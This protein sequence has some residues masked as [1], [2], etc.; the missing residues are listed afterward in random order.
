MHDL[1]VLVVDDSKV[2]RVTMMK[3]LEAMGVKVD[4]V[5]S[6][7]Q[8]LEYLAQGTPDMIFMDHMMP[9]MDGF[10]VTRRIKANPAT[11]NIPVVIISGNEEA[12]FV[13]EARAAGAVHAVVKPP[14][15]E[16]LEA[17][18]AGLPA[19]PAPASLPSAAPSVD[20]D[21]MHALVD[22]LVA[23]AAANLREAVMAEIA[24]R[25]AAENT[26]QQ[27][28]LGAWDSR[29]T[30]QAAAIETLETRLQAVEQR[31]AAGLDERQ[32]GS[33]ALASRL[34]NLGQ[35]V[36]SLQAR[37]DAHTALAEQRAS[38]WAQRLDSFARTLDGYTQDLPPLRAVQEKLGELRNE[39]QAG[40][41][42]ELQRLTILLAIGAVTFL[43]TIG[44]FLLWG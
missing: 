28:R 5:E 13:E 14:A 41:R 4:L 22:R 37:V 18:L 16:V 42:R 26:S 11:R 43:A 34:E 7:P 12:L 40:L 3:K 15:N 2:G 21:A 9:E 31:I 1:R 8:A 30:R 23:E 19:T 29:L 17:L 20:M 24:A 10:E 27:Q 32:A 38:D 35:Q 36:L 6:G 39:L 33:D 25:L 44:G